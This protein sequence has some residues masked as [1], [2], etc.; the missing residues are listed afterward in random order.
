LDALYA[1]RER[2]QTMGTRG[3]EK[4]KSMNLSWQ[5]VVESII[6]GAG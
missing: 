1:D 5:H 6:N 4:L 2:A 3:Q